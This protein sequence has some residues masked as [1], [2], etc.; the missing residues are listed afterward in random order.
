MV[1]PEVIGIYRTAK[2]YLPWIRYVA[3]RKT[4]CYALRRLSRRGADS[5]KVYP[6]RK[7]S[8][9]TERFFTLLWKSTLCPNPCLVVQK[10]FL[11]KRPERGGSYRALVVRKRQ[12]RIKSGPVLMKPDCHF[13]IPPPYL[14]F[15]P[16]K[17]LWIFSHEINSNPGP[18]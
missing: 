6:Y 12:L 17:N 14:A 9:S 13:S 2:G 8:P 5:N 16:S 11:L 18:I 15:L 4:C 3:P 1:L 7:I 10:W